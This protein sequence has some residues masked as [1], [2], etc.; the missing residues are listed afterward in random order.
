[1]IELSDFWYRATLWP[2]LWWAAYY[3]A[4]RY[5]YRRVRD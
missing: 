5:V 2:P 1:M 3:F 4:M